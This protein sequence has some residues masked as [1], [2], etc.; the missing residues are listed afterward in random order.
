MTLHAEGTFTVS[1]WDENAYAELE[2]KGKLTKA[3]VAFDF[4][5][6]LTAHGAW[7]AVM[8]YRPDG[9]AVFTGMQR[10]TGEV[11]GRAGSFVALANG[12]FE[13]GEAR[14]AWQVIDG[15]GT[16]ELAGLRGQGSSLSSSSPGGTFSF[17]YELG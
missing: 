8:C 3:T 17:D 16:A 2:G 14:T 15:S 6:D 7:D 4:T 5:G 12:T 13:G 1:S 11:G 9:T 10:M